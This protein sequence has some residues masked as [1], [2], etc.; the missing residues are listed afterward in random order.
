MLGVGGVLLAAALLPWAAAWLVE[1]SGR[2]PPEILVYLDRRL[3]GHPRWIALTAPL[4]DPLRAHYGTA[5]G[6]AP[7]LPLAP[8]AL[9][10]NPRAATP[11]AQPSADAPNVL[12]VGPGRRFATV[13]QAAQAARPGD[14]VEVDPGD[15]VADPA[16]WT[17]PGLTVRGLGD[18]VRIIAAGAGAEGKAIWV[19]RAERMTIE[20][21]QF[22]GVRVSDGNGAGIRLEQGQLVVRR[23]AFIDNEIGILT[24][25]E[26]GVR[27]DVED[28]EFGWTHRSAHF[29]HL[30]YVGAIEHLRVSGSYFHHGDNGHLLKSR[31]RFNRIEYNRLSDESGGRASYE[32]EFPNGG[33]AEV[34]GN[35]IQQGAGSGNSVVVSFGAEGYQAPVNELRFVH[36]TVVNDLPGGGT[37]VRAAP[38][39]GA[40]VVSRNNVFVGPGR[41]FD[42]P[43][44]DSEGDLRAD[45]SELVRPAREDWRLN[46]AG[47][48]HAGGRPVA[49][50]APGLRPAAEYVHP[51]RTR[52]LAGPP[53]WPGALQ[54]EPR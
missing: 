50:V 13:G 33:I 34:V 43:A 31:A 27:L 14:V 37:F 45:W 51:A 8:P 6:A 24:S 48:A 41:L 21:V 3:E 52:P 18:R 22:F 25:A 2:T 7:L 15:Y 26:P 40:G 5:P 1:R 39:G 44:V 11:G 42:A 17:A 20:N 54:D 4:L 10:P 49:A 9:A 28:S 30:L 29:T 19:V 38:G 35:L 23:C 46:D 32:L 47:R 12:R 36:N 53:R 16:V